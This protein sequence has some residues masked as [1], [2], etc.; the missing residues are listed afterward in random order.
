MKEKYEKFTVEARKEIKDLQRKIDDVLVEWQNKAQKL[1][2]AQGEEGFGRDFCE[3]S[4]VAYIVVDVG[5]LDESLYLFLDGMDT[6]H[7]ETGWI[8]SSYMD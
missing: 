7:G 3:Y 4:G 2:D 5:Y 6:G 1:Y 8:P